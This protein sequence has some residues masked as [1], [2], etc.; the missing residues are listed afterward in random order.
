VRK[1]WARYYD[2]VTEADAD[3]GKRLKELDDAGLTEDT[4]V[5]YWADHGSG[6][7]RSKR[8]PCDS[9]PH[10]PLVVYI[11]TRF[12]HLA[13]PEYLPGGQS[14]RLVSFV[15]LAPTVRALAG[16]QPPEWMQGN[17]FLG[18]DIKPRQP[19]L[20]GF[21]GRMDERYDP[22]RSVTD[23]R[24]VYLR[25]YLPQKIYGQHIDYMFQTPTTQVWK[26]LHDQGKLTP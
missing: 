22:V 14:A 3:A 9:G 23:G 26:R 10:G 20:H 24:Y 13:P 11:P 7:P 16:I 8:W 5:F 19:F 25:N 6:M 21:R 4:I 15:D 1:D 17:A 2:I 18:R 12:R